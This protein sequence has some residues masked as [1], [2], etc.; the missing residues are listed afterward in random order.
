MAETPRAGTPNLFFIMNKTEDVK[1]YLST[2]DTSERLGLHRNT[3][4]KFKDELKPRKALNGRDNIY[5]PA[6]VDAFLKKRLQDNPDIEP[7]Y[8]IA[9]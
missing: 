6:L 7:N 9:R 4:V 2:A 5:D 3:L 1:E 8:K